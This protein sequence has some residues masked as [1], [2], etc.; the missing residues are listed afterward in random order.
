MNTLAC[1]R[2]PAAVV[3]LAFCLSLPLVGATAAMASEHG[4]EG[5]GHDSGVL[6]NDF[7]KRTINVGL[8]AV[9]IFIVLRKPAAAFFSGRREQIAA[10]LADLERARDEAKAQLREY[11][12]K[13][14]H[15]ISECDRIMA[16]FAAQGEV[17]KQRI[18]KEAEASASRLKDAARLTIE[19]EVKSAK[20][21]IREELADA[22]IDLAEQKLRAG[23]SAQDQDRLIDDYLKKV[24][25]LK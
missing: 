1:L 14:A 22:A 17:E 12:N 2:K 4:A 19:A 6:L 20:R 7:I 23:V 9:G 21:Q 15:A 11:E 8:L 3:A 16:E 5:G 24:V 18:L 25:D 13:L 10:Q